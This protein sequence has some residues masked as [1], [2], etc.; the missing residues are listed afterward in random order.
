MKRLIIVYSPNSA[1]F[2]EVD[3]K[4]IEKS[5]KL[6]GWMVA[7]FEVQEIFANENVSRLAKIIR[8]GDLVLSAGGDGT[9]TTALNA[10]IKSGEIATLAV[11]PF[12]NFNDYAETLGK[13]SFESIIRKFEE[14]RYVDFYPLDVKVNGK[15]Y[16]YSGL[17]FTVGMMAESV[18]LM[19]RPN[20]RRRLAKAK[21]RMAFSAKKLFGWYM[22]NKWRKD[23]LPGGMRINDVAVEKSSTDYVALN[24]GSMAG[25]VPGGVWY[26]SGRQFWSG[27]MRNRSFWRMF[28]KFL[29][30]IEGELPGSESIGDKLT[31]KKPCKIFVH[32]EGEGEELKGVSEI[33]VLKT[34]KG[35]RVIKA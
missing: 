16:I 28:R 30:A 27:T 17:Y 18:K 32:A 22:K 3:K 6:K 31:F 9:A 5:R 12:G 1:R 21:N 20:V 4:V 23:L 19:K 26:R 33:S 14:G 29:L 8:K 35:L 15:H 10:I 11:M 13:M 24:G 2:S 34:G 25:V 7:K